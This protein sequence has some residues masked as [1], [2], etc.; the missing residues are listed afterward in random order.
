MKSTKRRLAALMLCAAL[1]LSAAVP[2]AAAGWADRALSYAIDT[3][4]LPA[5]SLRPT[6]FATR[7]FDTITTADES[8]FFPLPRELRGQA[9]E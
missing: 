2:S 9:A 1:F 3:G 7:G 5:A 4:M 6:D 8:V